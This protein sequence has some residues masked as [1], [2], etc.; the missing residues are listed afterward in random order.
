[1]QRLDIIGFLGK[2][3][4][5]KDFNNDQVINFSV[6]V[7][8]SYKDKNGVKQ[9]KS[10][11]YEVSKWGSNTAIAQYLKKGTQVLVTGKPNARIWTK[12]GGE[13]NIILTIQ[14]QNIQLLGGG[15]TES[16]EK[17][18]TQQSPEQQNIINEQNDDL[19]F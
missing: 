17:N 12:D 2:D 6:A 4:E 9:T 15:K 3:A 10:T 18:Q 19:P 7:T 1:M 8:E 13:H 16:K 5:V 11:W 14:A